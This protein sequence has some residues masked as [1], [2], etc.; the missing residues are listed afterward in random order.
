MPNLECAKLC[1]FLRNNHEIAALVPRLDP[2]PY[3][4]FFVRKDYDD[5]YYPKELFKN[6]CQYGGRA[7][8]PKLYLPY[9]EEVERTIP[10]MKIYEPYADYYCINKTDRVQ[11][12][13]LLNCAHIRLAPDSTEPANVKRI[14]RML[15]TG[16]FSGIIFHDYDLGAIKNA[17]EVIYDFQQLRQLKSKNGLKEYEIGS[18]F[19][20]QCSSSEE[21]LNWLNVLPMTNTFSLQYNG[22]MDNSTLNI[23]CQNNKKMIHQLY[24]KISDARSDENHFLMNEAREIF[25]QLLFLRRQNIKILLIYDE[26]FFP[27]KEMRDLIDL[28]NCWMS[29]KWAENSFIGTETLHKFCQTYNRFCFLNHH[30]KRKEVTIEDVRQVFLYLYERNYDLFQ[31][32]YKWEPVIYQGGQLINE[33]T[34]D[35]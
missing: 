12:K 6:N 1:T 29:F 34:G 35:S 13:R 7:F 17:Y 32:F 22:I 4:R 26:D 15:N 8:N 16:K 3:T 31:M 19:P 2:E 33:W 30:F 11:F 24:Y 10:N 21:I 25:K 9:K 14:E 20:I 5:G 23:L 27:T 28:W 18:K